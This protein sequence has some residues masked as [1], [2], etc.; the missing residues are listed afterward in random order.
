MCGVGSLHEFRDANETFD[1]A[2][3]YY[4]CHHQ[5]CWYG[6]GMSYTF[7][8]VLR[9]NHLKLRNLLKPNPLQ[10][11]LSNI[12][13]KAATTFTHQLLADRPTL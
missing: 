4:Y 11:C 1:P 10:G 3:T 8:E 9:E 6:E 13:T 12:Q 5:H 2:T 7:S